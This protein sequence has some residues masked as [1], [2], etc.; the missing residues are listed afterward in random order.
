MPQIPVAR[1]LHVLTGG[2]TPDP[3]PH[4][5]WAKNEFPQLLRHFQKCQGN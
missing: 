1:I 3:Q 4:P 2:S 5:N